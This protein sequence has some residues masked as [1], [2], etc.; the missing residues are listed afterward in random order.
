MNLKVVYILFLLVRSVWCW[1][2]AP[3]RANARIC[4]QKRALGM[5]KMID[6]TRLPPGTGG[7]WPG[8]PNALKH[9]VT[10]VSPNGE[11]A[12]SLKVPED[13]FI[14]SYFEEQ[15]I[16]LP[17]RNKDSMCREGCCTTCAARVQ[18][19][20][21]AMNEPLGLSKQMKD[22]GYALICSSCPQSAVVLRLQDEDEV[23]RKQWSDSFE[24]GGVRWGGLLPDH[25]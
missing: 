21:V 11:E 17:I 18:Q 19:G 22:E 23:Y 16:D 3:F 6:C 20:E 13:R 4:T 14:F 2:R 7:K 12:F 5:R 8:D 24:S 15:G 1:W 9:N 25:D 10:I